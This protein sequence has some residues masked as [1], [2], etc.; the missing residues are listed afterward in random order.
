MS[1]HLSNQVPIFGHLHDF[2]SF[3]IKKMC[4]DA[5]SH[6][7]D[8]ILLFVKELTHFQICVF[9]FNSI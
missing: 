2:Q 4:H 8:Y 5:A 9:N 1:H 6:L 7:L 3:A